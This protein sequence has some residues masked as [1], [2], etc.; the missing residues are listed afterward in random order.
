VNLAASDLIVVGG[1]AAGLMAAGRAAELGARVVLLEKQKRLG[2]KLSISGKGRC[3]LTNTA[4]LN[5][6]LKRY[7]KNGKF[8]R[9]AFN[10]FFSDELI[11]FFTRQGVTIKSERG[12]RVFPENDNAN[13]VVEALVGWVKKRGVAIKMESPVSRLVVENGHVVGLKIVNK[14]V[15]CRSVIIATGGVSYPATGSTGDGYAF[16]ELVG[17]TVVPVRPALIGLKANGPTC[18]ALQGLSLKN[19]RA[20]LWVDGKK[21]ADQFGEMLFTHFGLSG[22]I[23]L[24]LSREAVD[25]L[26]EG[27]PTSI[28]IDLKPALD[29]AKLDARLLREIQEHGK[30]EFHTLLKEL[31]P[32]KLIEPACDLVG[33]QRG[34]QVS[35]VS[36]A[37][38]RRLVNWLK[39]FRFELKGYRNPEEAIVT[40]GGVALNEIDPRTMQSKLVEGLFFA[41]ETIDVDGET[42]GFN[43]QAAFSTGWLAGEAAAQYLLKK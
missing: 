2:H 37:Q 43:L 8:L 24:T 17:H 15:P 19:V 3:N 22:P 39:D 23:I 40:A 16:A 36:A 9:Q 5:E 7:G 26:R 12:G 42:G 25:A 31:L 32:S 30:R 27:L 13:A 4:P 6:F 34:L 20:T 18:R 10:Q 11:Q 38:R 28:A 29:E 21:R 14:T 35:Q 1:G 41:G 33:I